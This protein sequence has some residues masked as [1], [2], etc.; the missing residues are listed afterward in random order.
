MLTIFLQCRSK[1]FPEKSQAVSDELLETKVSFRFLV[2]YS[3][4]SA[5]WPDEIHQNS[6]GTLVLS[7]GPCKI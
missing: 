5:D 3:L 2:V 6:G 4:Q 1:S 7:V